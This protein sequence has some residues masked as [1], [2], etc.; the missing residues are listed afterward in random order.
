MNWELFCL[1]TDCNALSGEKQWLTSIA[2]YKSLRYNQVSFLFLTKALMKADNQKNLTAG[3][4]KELACQLKEAFNTVSPFIEKHTAIVCPECETVCCA[5]KHGRYDSNDLLFH[6]SLG[7]EIPVLSEG[8]N[9][10]DAC[11]FIG[12]TGCSRER[13]MR[14]YRCTF[15]FCDSLLKSLENDNAKLYRAFRDY[16]QYL[17]SLRHELIG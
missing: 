11:R 12:E 9:E 1:I 2:D 7:T 4:R 13:W 16:F 15:F 14:P 10:N 5:D 17:V 6:E 8:R 3:G